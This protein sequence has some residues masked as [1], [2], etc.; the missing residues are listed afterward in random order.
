M[1]FIRA[2]VDAVQRNL[3]ALALYT[4]ALLLATVGGQAAYWGALQYLQMDPKTY[5]TGPGAIL[6]MVVVSAVF[7]VP[8]TAAFAWMGRDIDKPLWR[9]RDDW[10]AIK[11]FYLLW[12]MLDLA[13]SAVWQFTAMLYW[14]DNPLA[15]FGKAV[16]IML[17]MLI[18]PVGGCIMFS[19]HMQWRHL[20]EILAPLTRQLPKTGILVA[21]GFIQ[22]WLLSHISMLVSSPTEEF[23]QPFD[24]FAVTAALML[25]NSYLDCLIFAGVWLLCMADRDSPDDID[26]DF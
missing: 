23:P 1:E 14:A 25:I 17:S 2:A 13:M 22:V 5:W 20:P 4:V 15:L 6:T 18:I 8:R 24:H 12:L 21:A 11:R 16:S 7:A 10:D 3:P 19:G 26:M 9:V